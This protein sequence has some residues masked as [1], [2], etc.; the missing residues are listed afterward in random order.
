MAAEF[1]AWA[2]YYDLIHPGLP[3]EA[4]FYAGQ[5]VKRGGPLLEIGCGTGRIALPIAL[6][7]LPVIGLDN[8]IPMLAVCRE[9]QAQ[10]EPISGTLDLIAADMRAFSLKR[11]FPLILM[12]YRTFMHCLNP[13]EQLA[14]LDCIYQH[15]DTGG[16]L[17]CNLWAARPGALARFSSSYDENSFQW[18][19]TVEMPEEKIVLEHFHT[20]WRDDARQLLHE[21][22]WIQE[23]NLRGKVVH[24]E[25]L[26]LLRAWITPREMEHLVHRAGFSVVNVLGD[27]DGAPFNGHQDEMI[28]HLRRK[29]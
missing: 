14:C 17:L 8:S 4:A 24:E 11:R 2:A 1:D 25:Y 19:G 7:G 10:I 13:Q 15:L 22:H 5:A 27:F 3:G 26:P 28:W 16:E 21:M 9:K 29:K 12:A 23:K 20:A 18:V 6:S